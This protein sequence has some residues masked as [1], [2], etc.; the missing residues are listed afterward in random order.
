MINRMFI[1]LSI[2]SLAACAT[3]TIENP[4]ITGEMVNQQNEMNTIDLQSIIDRTYALKLESKQQ[5]ILFFSPYNLAQAEEAIVNLETA[6]SNNK[7][8]NELEALALSAQTYFLN[9]LSN[10]INALEQ[11]Q[12]S[13]D[14]LAM[15]EEMNTQE[16]LNSEYLD[17]KENLR[18]SVILIEEKELFS[19]INLQNKNLIHISKLK[20]KVLKSI[21]LNVAKDALEKAENAGAKDFAM[22]TYN[23]AKVY[24]DQLASYIE[25]SPDQRTAIKEKSGIAVRYAIHAENIAIAAKPLTKLTAKTAEVHI[26]FIEKLL[27]RIATALDSNDVSHLELNS[28]SISITQT[29][30]TVSKQANTQINI[31]IQIEVWNRE[32][33][34]LLNTIKN[35]KKTIN[36]DQYTEN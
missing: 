33:L 1:I 28:Q 24:I 3:S 4:Q 9:G 6:L 31:G 16:I 27:S 29:A 36:T 17:I 5:N 18:Q 10:K 7:S 23:A 26:L 12:L 20:I 8:T 19:A 30:E 21:Y 22:V 14:G 32:K 13:F 34:E 11:L 35:L 2:L 25:I 15:L